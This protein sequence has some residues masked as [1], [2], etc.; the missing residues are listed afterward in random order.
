MKVYLFFLFSFLLFTQ[1]QSNLSEWIK[2]DL[3]WN[4]NGVVEIEECVMFYYNYGTRPLPYAFIFHCQTKINETF[5][6]SDHLMKYI[7]S[8]FPDPWKK[9]VNQKVN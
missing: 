9:P 4:R 7:H 8:I 5:L 6:N 1:V 2:R 3:D